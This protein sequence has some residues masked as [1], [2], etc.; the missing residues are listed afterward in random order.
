MAPFGKKYSGPRLFENRVQFSSIHHSANGIKDKHGANLKS[1]QIPTRHADVKGIIAESNIQNKV[2]FCEP[3]ALLQF[4]RPQN[5]SDCTQ[6]SYYRQTRSFRLLT[7]QLGP[8]WSR[9]HL[10]LQF[11]SPCSLGEERKR[12][13]QFSF[14]FL[15][16]INLKAIQKTGRY[17][18]RS[19]PPLHTG[20]VNYPTPSRTGR[21]NCKFSV[22]QVINQGRNICSQSTS[23]HDGKES[24][25]DLELCT[26]EPQGTHSV[27]L[28]VA[29][30]RPCLFPSFQLFAL[31]VPHCQGRKQIARYFLYT[32][33]SYFLHE[34][35][36]IR[37]GLH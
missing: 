1:M 32:H 36:A 35:K 6:P 9:L 18:A 7:V 25:N 17:L 5:I 31:S 15:P 10:Q 14:C 4:K 27:D 21:E 37:Q 20:L 34:F 11:R 24:K 13:G 33:A 28:S 23:N 30:A 3:P 16:F 8:Y 29:C 19:S 2:S 26:T 12:I 22:S